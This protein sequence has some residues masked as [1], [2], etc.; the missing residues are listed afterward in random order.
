MRNWLSMSK[1]WG[2]NS[3][4]SGISHNWVLGKAEPLERREG[5]SY[6]RLMQYA[7]IQKEFGH[8]V[9]SNL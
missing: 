9:G 5:H 7:Q 6:R 2:F 3:K 8:V 1:V 4:I